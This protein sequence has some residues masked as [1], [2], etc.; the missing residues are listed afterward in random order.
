METGEETEAEKRQR[1][2]L[3]DRSD[4]GVWVNWIFS[5]KAQESRTAAFVSPTWVADLPVRRAPVS[6]ALC[7]DQERLIGGSVAGVRGVR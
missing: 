1:R 7:G 5:Q 4:D 2:I 6:A 3:S